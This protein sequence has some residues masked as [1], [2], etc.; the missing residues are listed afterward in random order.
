MSRGK[1]K[2]DGSIFVNGAQEKEYYSLD[3]NKLVAIA[4]DTRDE[5][6]AYRPFPCYSEHNIYN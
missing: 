3:G 1:N 6:S 2:F 4:D 5:F